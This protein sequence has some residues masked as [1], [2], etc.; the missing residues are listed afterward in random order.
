MRSGSGHLRAPG[1]AV[2]NSLFTAFTCPKILYGVF[3]SF[4]VSALFSSVLFLACQM[5]LLKVS[6][7]DGMI[8]FVLTFA[9]VSLFALT[10]TGSIATTAT[11]RRRG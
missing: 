11:S 9:I 5:P 2:K 4:R 10:L 3:L 8:I 7:G 6:F 1:G